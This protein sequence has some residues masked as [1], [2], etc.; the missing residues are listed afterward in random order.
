MFKLA[1]ELTRAV[2]L[3]AARTVA[4]HADM[5]SRGREK[6][7]PSTSAHVAAPRTWGSAATTFCAESDG[8]EDVRLWPRPWPLWSVAASSQPRSLQ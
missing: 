5:Q 7:E 2:I 4:T 1:G 3:V 6:W 8:P